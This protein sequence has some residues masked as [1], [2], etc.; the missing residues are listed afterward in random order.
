MMCVVSPAA[1]LVSDDHRGLVNNLSIE[2]V[3]VSDLPH[4]EPEGLEL[5]VLRGERR[6]SRGGQTDRPHSGGEGHWLGENQHGNVVAGRDVVQRREPVPLGVD[7]DPLHAHRLGDVG[8]GPVRHA[9]R[10]NKKSI[11]PGVEVRE[12]FINQ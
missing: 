11:F 1:V 6:V 8:P 2:P 12:G 10:H 5:H 7:D 9:L 3:R 4:T